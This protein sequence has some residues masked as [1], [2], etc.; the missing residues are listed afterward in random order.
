[1]ESTTQSAAAT[2][3]DVQA[4]ASELFAHCGAADY[5]MSRDD[6]AGILGQVVKK[7]L[8][9]GASAAIREFCLSLKIQEL[10]LARACAAGNERAWEVFMARYREKLYEVGLQITREDSAARELSDSL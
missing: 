1:M 10:V 4:V 9:P 2:P 8:E 6:L 7:Y 3:P 5:G